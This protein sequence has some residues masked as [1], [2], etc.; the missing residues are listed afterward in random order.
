MITECEQFP[1]GVTSDYVDTCTQAWLRI[2]NS[3]LLEKVVKLATPDEDDLD[4]QRQQ[5]A[6]GVYG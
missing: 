6:R 4:E 2:R 5:R 1:N 3:G